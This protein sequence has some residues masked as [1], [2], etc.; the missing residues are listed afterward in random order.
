MDSQVRLD[1]F[2]RVPV[3]VDD[4][5]VASA[6]QGFETMVLLIALRRFP[7]A[8]TTLATAIENSLQAALVGAKEKDGL[9]QLLGKAARECPRLAAW[10]P[11]SLQAL[12][13]LRN[14]FVHRG[15]S[16][17][18]DGPAVRSI[19]ST[20]LPLFFA[21]FEEML[22]F[23]ISDGLLED[24][25][26]HL[27]IATEVLRKGDRLGTSAE[28]Y[29]LNA[30]I[31]SVSWSIKDSF[32]APWEAHAAHRAHET[33]LQFELTSRMR[34][35]FEQGVEPFWELTCPI[36]FEFESATV[37]LDEASLEARA[38]RALKLTCCNCAFETL[39]GQEL[40]AE[41]LVDEPLQVM[42]ETILQE[43][44]IP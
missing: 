8:L 12:K 20:G 25:S 37:S 1:F 36:C 6:L 32:Q 4:D 10:D 23:S 22:D 29:C 15:F 16:A 19:I 11:S 14:R 24:Y 33:G 21:I 41:V 9:Q 30:L 27:D 18:D 34:R 42:K 13:D 28:A 39:P 17:Q 3:R 26:H 43:F 31:A 35:T 44:A 38:V 2:R 7:A 5:Y 40:L